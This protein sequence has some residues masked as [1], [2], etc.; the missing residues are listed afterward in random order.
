MKEAVINAVCHRDY[1]SQNN[2]F[3]NVFDDRIEV[4]SPGSIPNNL[5]LKEVYG[6]SNPRNY[7]IVELFKRIHFIEKL[8]SGLKR[9]DELMLLHG[10]KKPV[11]E[12]NTAFFKVFFYGP[13][14]RILE[15]VK[16]SNETDLRELGLNKLQV[17]ALSFLQKKGLSTRK[18][19]QEFLGTTK[20]T[21]TRYIK[22]LIE[23][24]FIKRQGES[25]KV[26]YKLL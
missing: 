2:V 20:K 3:V 1:F 14:E 6:T 19:L 17:K 15:L 9:M 16:P 8:G 23:K 26:K 11:Y 25:K 7:K 4:I 12:I 10:L 24:G 21:T 22:E 18:D 13:K 5:T